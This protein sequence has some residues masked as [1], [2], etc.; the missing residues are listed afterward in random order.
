MNFTENENEL[1]RIAKMFLDVNEKACL[2]G[3]LMLKLRGIDLGRECHDIDILLVKEKA[4]NVIKP[5]E[6]NLKDGES[7]SDGCSMCFLQE[8]G[9]KIDILS[10]GSETTE[11]INGY[12]LGS[13]SEL[14]KTKERYIKKD[15]VPDKK[16]VSDL[17]ILKTIRKHFV[18]WINHF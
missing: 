6:L 1:L 14:I 4:V 3:S 16:H 13:I 17:E 8:N 11:I 12:K 7:G 2:T 5:F 10:T 15:L 18:T 9:V